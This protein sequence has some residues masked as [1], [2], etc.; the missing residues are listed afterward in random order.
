MGYRGRLL[1][2][3]MVEI[4]PL[5]TGDT[6]ILDG[7]DHVLREP[8]KASD[9]ADVTK[10][11]EPYRL[12]AQFQPEKTPM[13]D[14]MQAPH[15][16]DPNTVLHTLFHYESLEDEGRVDDEGRPTIR[17]RDRLVAVYTEDG[18][19]IRDF[20]AEGSKGMFAAELQDRSFGL[21]GGPVTRNLLRVRWES[22]DASPPGSV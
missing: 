21:G 19:L 14:L 8:L 20:T 6:G 18:E 9:G 13:E 5:L 7:Y 17:L 16:S 3:V 10:Y 2:T 15:G 1:R 22:D 11:G 12:P 4:R